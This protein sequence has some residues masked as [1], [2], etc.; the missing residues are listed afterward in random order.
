[1]ILS[2]F[3]AWWERVPYSFSTS[4]VLLVFWKKVYRCFKSYRK[5]FTR[6][7]YVV[8]W[9]SR[10]RAAALSPHTFPSQ[11]SGGWPAYRV[12]VNISPQLC[13]NQDVT[14]ESHLRAQRQVL[15]FQ[16]LQ[17]P[18]Q[19]VAH[20]AAWGSF[21]FDLLISKGH[22]Q[23]KRTHRLTSTL[24]WCFPFKKKVIKLTWGSCWTRPHSPP[25]R[26]CKTAAAHPSGS[27]RGEAGPPGGAQVQFTTRNKLRQLVFWHSGYFWD[28][29]N[30]EKQIEYD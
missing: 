15:L 10:W 9:H 27:A 16:V 29:T 23:N 1:M 25:P 12:K 26:W 20:K 21:C 13:G 4:L 11:S 7:T 19:G 18:L 5:C 17:L 6:K 28:E 30:Y 3:H 22:Q 14:G 8:L 24:V 2:Y